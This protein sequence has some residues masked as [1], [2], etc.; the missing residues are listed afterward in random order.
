MRPAGGKEVHTIGDFGLLACLL[1]VELSRTCYNIVVS[2]DH[3][4]GRYLPHHWLVKRL[5][6]FT[7]RCA[8]SKDS[9]HYHAPWG[10]ENGML[11]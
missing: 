11:Q 4:L 6:A 10:R 9:D 2:L 3:R 5:E 8:V 1:I 7:S